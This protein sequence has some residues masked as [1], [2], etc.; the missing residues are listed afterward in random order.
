MHPVAADAPLSQPPQNGAQRSAVSR[1]ARLGDLAA[2]A[3]LAQGAAVPTGT[4]QCTPEMIQWYEE[5]V[6][7]KNAA[8]QAQEKLLAA[9]LRATAANAANGPRAAAVEMDF[10]GKVATTPSALRDAVKS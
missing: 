3:Q 9:E 4:A 6:A 8:A 1:R 7:V 10:T 2:E 5:I